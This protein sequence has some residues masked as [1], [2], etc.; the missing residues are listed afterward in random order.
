MHSATRSN[1]DALGP[2]A[3]R[4]SDIWR[5]KQLEYAWIYAGIYSGVSGGMGDAAARPVPSFSE[6]TR[7]SLDYALT[8]S[9]SSQDLA[10]RLLAS[11]QRL[12][13]FADVADSLAKLKAGGGRLAI[14]SN[15]DP[16]FLEQLVG[17]AQL[18][19]MFDRLLSV[20]AAGTFKPSP[21][22]YQL[23]TDAFGC[24]PGDITF[25]SANRWDCAGA[26][27]FGFRT[28]WVN[29]SGAPSEY[30]DLAADRV[31]ADLSGGALA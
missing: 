7:L 2:N 22:V 8:A 30:A 18:R 31:V 10:P 19:G 28:V 1:A 13:P 16:D 23:A 3:Q 29:R 9:G 17:H 25:V 26:K 4:F 14:L 27:A 6:I 12:A 20:S 15:A 21:R 11:Y 24:Q 5:A